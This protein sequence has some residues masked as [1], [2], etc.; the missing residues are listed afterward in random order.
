MKISTENTDWGIVYYYN[1]KDYRFA[2]YMYNDDTDSLYLSNV[3]VNQNMRGQG[4]GNKILNL[5]DE[6]AK[7]FNVS[8][9]YLKVLEQE[10]MHNWYSKHGYSDFC[11]DEEDQNYIWMKKQ[12]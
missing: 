9:I 8:T 3:K 10:W 12:V 7:K 6:E 4:I 1:D 11:Y 2:L 5:V